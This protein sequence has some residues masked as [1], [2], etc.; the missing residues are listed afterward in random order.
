MK[1]TEKRQTFK[2]FLYE[3]AHEFWLK[4]QQAH[5]LPTEVQMN[6]DLQDWAENLTD[7]EKKVIGGVLKGFIQ[8]ELVV[9]DYWTTKVT[10]WFPHP[11]IVMMGTAFGSFETI[12]GVGY[13]YLNDSLGIKD[14]D[15]FLQEPAAKA[16]IDRLIDISGNNKEDIARSLAIFSGFTEGVSLFSSFAILFN[17]S[18]FNKL[19]GVGQIISW[20][21]RDEALHS[22][23]GCWLFREFI[24]ENPEVWT[25][26]VKRDI[27]Q[28]ARDTVELEDKFIDVVF[29]EGSIEGLDP[30]D[31]KQFIRFRANTKLGELGLKM[32]WKNIDQEAVK[33]MSW[34]DLMTTG[35]E[36]TDFFAQRVSSYSKGH[37][38]FSKIFE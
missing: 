27:Y 24:K 29:S 20:S 6:S 30:K 31:L 28:A 9:N 21:I 15:A 12:H 36:H 37:I 19:K 33:R 3:K 5:W 26:E 11:E 13:A 23:A 18:R 4:Q 35:V 34:F 25:D 14:Y 17:F 32:N 1:L 8:T 38:D 16:K 2:P 10:N 22:E 7:K